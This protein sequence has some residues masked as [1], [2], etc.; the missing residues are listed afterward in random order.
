MKIAC[1]M[2]LLD[3]ADDFWAVGFQF[4]LTQRGHGVIVHAPEQITGIHQQC[5]DVDVAAKLEV[6]DIFYNIF[7]ALKRLQQLRFKACVQGFF[8][9]A[10]EHLDGDASAC[11]FMVTGNHH[12]LARLAKLLLVQLILVDRAAETLFN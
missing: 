6:F 10:V 12:S 4:G 3:G 2:D 5:N 1:F 9:L 11:R 8:T 7:G